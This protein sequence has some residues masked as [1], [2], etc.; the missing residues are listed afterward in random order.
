MI[1]I[2]VLSAVVSGLFSVRL[3]ACI[4]G[5]RFGGWV[6]TAFRGRH[7]LRASMR[8]WPIFASP[9]SLSVWWVVT[10]VRVNDGRL[11]P[12]ASATDA[13]EVQFR[14]A[15][16][17]RWEESLT[18]ARGCMDTFG[19]QGRCAPFSSS[20]LLKVLCSG[21]LLQEDRRR[22]EDRQSS[23]LASIGHLRNPSSPTS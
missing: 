20:P 12:K 1:F 6:R 17:N 13:N 5:R 2:L 23:W 19:R 8:D 7:C 15:V 3:G 14:W 18:A 4:W 22:A 10:A 11:R 9:L 16:V 21:P